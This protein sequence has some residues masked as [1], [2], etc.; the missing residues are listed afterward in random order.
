MRG[1]RLPRLVVWVVSALVSGPRRDFVLG[2][3][4]EDFRRRLTSQG[5][6]RAL[7]GV[8]IEVARSAGPLATWSLDGRG[9][10][11]R[12]LGQDWAG[13]VRVFGRAPGFAFTVVATLALGIGGATAVY[14]VLRGVVLQPLPFDDPE[15]VVVLWGETPEYPRAPLTVGD[16]NAL[17]DGVEAFESVAASWTNTTL[18]L[19]GARAEQVRVGWVTPGYF[20]TVGVQPAL[21]RTP[22]AGEEAH[23]V[24]GHGLWERRYGSDPDVLGRT[25]DLGGERFQV[26]GVLPAGR[27]PDLTAFGGGP[28]NH[29][30]W[31]LMPAGWV[32]GDDR[33]VGWLRSS[34]R[35]APGVSAARAQTE[36]D[37]L[38]ARVN[39]TVTDRDG[40]G[41]LRVNVIPARTDLVGDAS[42]TLWILMAAVCGVLLVAAANVANLLLARG[43]GR[44]AEVAVRAALGGGRGR[45]VRQFLVE[46]ATLAGAG[47][48]AGLG[49]AWA[50]VAALRAAAP[51]E[52]PRLE[53]V[54]LDGGV[55]AFAVLATAATALMFGLFPAVRASRSDLAAAMAARRATDDPGSRRWSRALVVAQVALSLALVS[56]TGLL[57]RSVSGLR[58]VDLGFDR[59]GVLTFALEAP[60]WGEGDAGA[61]AKMEDFTRSMEA[62][63]G[64]EAVGFTNRVPL[65]GGLF[66]GTV[67][68]QDMVAAEDDALEASLRYVTAGYLDALNV[69]VVAGRSLARDDDATVGL[70]DELVA[71]RLWPGQEALGRPL[72]VQSVGGDPT[73]VEVVGVVAAM[74]HAGVEA[75]AAET[76]LL[77]MPPRAASQ[78]FRYVAARVTGDPLAVVEPIRE[79]VEA[80]DAQGVVA[81]VRTMDDLFDASVAPTRFAS[82]LLL[83]FGGVALLLA[84][85]G[86]HGVMAFTVRRR[87]REMGIRMAL[88]AERD[89]ILR[90]A[91]RS[92]A[93][94]V[95]AGLAVGLLLALAGGSFLEALLYEVDARDVVTLGASAAVILAAGLLGAWVPARLVL[96]IDPVKA[97]RSD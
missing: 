4:E 47:A 7:V 79:A 42:R 18:L 8:W 3:L 83:V 24:L 19:G 55:V 28:T 33:S 70:V 75:P 30:L 31:R 88:G 76:V 11:M 92:G 66:T 94:L 48:V 10:T 38:M 2:D 77:P 72:Q 58:D 23:V 29:D 45:L 32:Q 6:V 9:G 60:S 90:D 20:E 43:E 95:L 1:S 56:G 69:R 57:L 63:P 82:Q 40:G 73:W 22:A 36:V 54:T 51:A 34:A 97:L 87:A 93:T 84:T 52:L 53:A 71:R 37:A 68:S 85:V 80:V 96:G 15:R 81:R 35:L 16:H 13:A 5:R 65:A 89:R 91:F 78:N 41:D 12:G 50:G 17:V 64:V 44:A 62:V 46:S 67:S 26:V 61:A 14:S 39:A 25:V 74:K 86:L 59:D 21:G 27:D 49:V